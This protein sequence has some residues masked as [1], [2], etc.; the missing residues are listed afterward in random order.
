[1]GHLMDCDTSM[2]P[3][4]GSHHARTE[5]ESR[6]EHE[7]EP[8]SAPAHRYSILTFGW[9]PRADSIAR[10]FAHHDVE[11]ASSGRDAFVRSN[12]RPFD[13]YI[14]DYFAPDWGG[15]PL[16]REI[17]KQDP[18]VPVIFYSAYEDPLAIRRTLRAG[19]NVYL[20]ERTGAETLA[21]RVM[22]LLEAAEGK[23]AMA[24]QSA[25]VAITAEA[26]RLA[27][28]SKL[29]GAASALSLQSRLRTTHLASQKAFMAA[30]GTRASFERW[31][32]RI[33]SVSG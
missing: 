9:G 21:R 4:F 2:T 32:A 18:H 10:M 5:G 6:Q 7:R 15:A 28:L 3:A 22:S 19:A 20:H 30:G 25:Q 29:P 1:M 23:N 27:A 12:A 14:L 8:A 24:A 17:R 26:G 16:T 11:F 33:G 31:W 13:A